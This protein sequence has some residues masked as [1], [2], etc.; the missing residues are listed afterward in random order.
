MGNLN[1]YKTLAE[2][3]QFYNCIRIET[4]QEFDNYFN[5]IQTNSNGYAFRSIN[6]AKFKLYSSAQ[7][8]WIWNDLSNAHTSFNNYILWGRKIN[9]VMRRFFPSSSV[10]DRPAPRGCTSTPDER[11]VTTI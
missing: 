2:K 8:Q 3:E 9:C 10:G 4:E 11:K 7:R 5:Q 6:E 1:E